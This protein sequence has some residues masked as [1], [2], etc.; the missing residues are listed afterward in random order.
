[1]PAR[2][3]P[4]T[5]LPR[6]RTLF[7]R[8]GLRARLGWYAPGQR[9]ARHAHPQHQCSL[10]LSGTLGEAAAGDDIRLAGTAAGFKAAGVDHANDYGPSGALIFGVDV[11]AALHWPDDGSVVGPGWRWQ[12]A[13][14]AALLQRSRHL[15]A[16][17]QANADPDLEARLWELVAVLADP[18][19]APAARKQS[20]PLWLA[21]MSARLQEDRTPLAELAREAGLH[22]VYVSRAFLRWTGSTPSALR[23][24]ARVQRAL[25]AL[26]AGRPLVDAALQAGFADH[27]HFSR[28]ARACVGLSPRQLCALLA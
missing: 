18:A 4:T 20:P 14:A 1:M 28:A 23:V 15:L 9:M 11:D 13:P 27:A 25:A 7:Q 5:A 3:A 12:R 21:R 17:L 6:V 8:H 24:R 22:P 26:T 16:D 2:Q 10:L 19:L